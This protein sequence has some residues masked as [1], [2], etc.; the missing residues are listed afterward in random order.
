VQE[1]TIIPSDIEDAGPNV[2]E[3]FLMLI[4]RGESPTMA[5]I[6]TMRQAPGIRTE[7]SEI[8][9]QNQARGG[10][11]LG[12][13]FRGNQN[14]LDYRIKQARKHGYNPSATDYYDCTVANFPG[15]P[16]AWTGAKQTK[17]DVRREIA[18]YGGGMVKGDDI[19]L[20]PNT[21]VAPTPPKKLAE[22]IVTR[23]EQQMVKDDPGL[24]FKDRR[25]LRES[26]KDKHGSQATEAVS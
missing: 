25:E 17:G 9:A 8:A 18:K 11:S 22:K 6:F 10:N 2:V 4:D 20:A 24:A 16:K 12:T 5:E 7:A 26:I 3:Y 23:I 19:T 1:A 15:D 13:Q 21:D 14:L